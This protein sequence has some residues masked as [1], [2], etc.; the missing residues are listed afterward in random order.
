MDKDNNSPITTSSSN[1]ILIDNI[2]PK[3][4]GNNHSN[5]NSN[6]SRNNNSVDINLEDGECR[7]TNKEVEDVFEET[8]FDDF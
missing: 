3:H 7:L 2:S 6:P 5:P 4:T 8:N 1:P